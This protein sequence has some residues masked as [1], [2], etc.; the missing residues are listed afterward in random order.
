MILHWSLVDDVAEWSS[1]TMRRHLKKEKS[2]TLSEFE[3]NSAILSFLAAVLSRFDRFA[4]GSSSVRWWVWSTVTSTG[5]FGIDGLLK[6]AGRWWWASVKDGVTRDEVTGSGKE[7]DRSILPF[8]I[9]VCTDSVDPALFSGWSS[10]GLSDRSGWPME[11]STGGGVSCSR[12]RSSWSPNPSWSIESKSISM[13]TCDVRGSIG[14]D[15]ASLIVSTAKKSEEIMKRQQEYPRTDLVGIPRFL[16]DKLFEYLLRWSQKYLYHC[17]DFR[18]SLKVYLQSLASWLPDV[19]QVDFPSDTFPSELPTVPLVDVEYAVGF[20]GDIH[21]RRSP[22]IDWSIDCEILWVRHGSPV[23]CDLFAYRFPKVMQ[24]IHWA[25][26]FHLHVQLVVWL[27]RVVVFF[28]KSISF[29][30]QSIDRIFEFLCTPIDFHHLPSRYRFDCLFVGSQ[31]ESNRSQIRTRMDCCLA[32]DFPLRFDWS[33]GWL[34]MSF[35]C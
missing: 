18:S 14:V 24:G 8:A 25:F 11:F 17:Y 20:H 32:V 13:T 26:P 27:V 9:A 12:K 16:C 33:V 6:D 4:L 5:A 29:L 22:R 1:L 15:G 19:Q 10:F 35:A 2:Q 21:R 28:S 3:S 34:C 23:E 31:T 30:S 7:T